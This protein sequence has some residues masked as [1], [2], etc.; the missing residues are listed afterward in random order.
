MSKVE[1]IIPQHL[2]KSRN[3]HDPKGWIK[4]YYYHEG[5]KILIPEKDISEY[6]VKTAQYFKKGIFYKLT[7][8]NK[9]DIFDYYKVLKKDITEDLYVPYKRSKVKKTPYGYSGVIDI[10]KFSKDNPFILHFD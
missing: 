3:H 6:I 8:S 7:Q 2:K 4:C 5:D 1:F 9:D 10:Q